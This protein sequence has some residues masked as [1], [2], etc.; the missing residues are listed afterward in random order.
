MKII[1]TSHFWGGEE[2]DT[3]S[4]LLGAHYLLF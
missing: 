3:N 4:L 1:T 2:L